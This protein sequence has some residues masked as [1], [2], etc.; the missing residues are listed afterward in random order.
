M[1]T[2]RACSQI[3]HVCFRRASYVRAMSNTERAQIV[4]FSKQKFNSGPAVLGLNCDQKHHVFRPINSSISP[5]PARVLAVMEYR[6]LIYML[7][8]IYV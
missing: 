8:H 6:G 5:T 3:L 4:I 7:D 1:L 2:E